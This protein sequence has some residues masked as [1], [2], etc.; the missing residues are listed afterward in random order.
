MITAEEGPGS[1][2]AVVGE[3]QRLSVLRCRFVRD[4]AMPLPGGLGD[5][6]AGWE[7]WAADDRGTGGVVGL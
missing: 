1:G 7:S 6:G 3:C 2:G 4:P 5:F